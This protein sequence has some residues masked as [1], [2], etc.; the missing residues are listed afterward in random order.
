M[1]I[2]YLIWIQWLPHPKHHSDLVVLRVVVASE[3]VALRHVLIRVRKIYQRIRLVK[4]E[5]GLVILVIIQV[6]GWCSKTNFYFTL[7]P[8]VWLIRVCSSDSMSCSEL[9]I[10]K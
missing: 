6:R 1:F 10:Y 5:T 8:I 4:L 3:D 9:L 2:V 7:Q